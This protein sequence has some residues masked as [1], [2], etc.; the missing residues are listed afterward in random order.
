MHESEGDLLVQCA[1]CGIEIRPSLERGFV[2]ESDAVLCYDCAERRGG[3]WDEE[4]GIWSGSPDL[5]GLHP[6]DP[7]ER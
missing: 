1:D 2:G 4:R 6:P 7:S 5:I 3:T